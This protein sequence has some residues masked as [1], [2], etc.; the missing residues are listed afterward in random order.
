MH[1]SEPGLHAIRPTLNLS[2]L[3]PAILVS[4]VL[5]V[6]LPIDDFVITWNRA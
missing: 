2:Q 5:A 6:I 1:L 4:F 3:R